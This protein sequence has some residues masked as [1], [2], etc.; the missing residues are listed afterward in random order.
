M[1]RVVPGADLTE[2]PEGR[3][4]HDREMEI[5]GRIALGPSIFAA[6]HPGGRTR[7]DRAEADAR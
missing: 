2:L 1:G 5:C 3:A 6:K 7:L 4:G